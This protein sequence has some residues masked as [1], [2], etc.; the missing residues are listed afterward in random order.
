[1]FLS[2]TLGSKPEWVSL[3]AHFTIHS[4]FLLVNKQLGA[5]EE[6]GVLLDYFLLNSV[7]KVPGTILIFILRIYPGTASL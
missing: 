1:M 2:L 7:T 3:A 4:P 5:W 6:G